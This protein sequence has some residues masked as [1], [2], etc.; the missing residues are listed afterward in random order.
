M[1][2][3]SY[4]RLGLKRKTIIILGLAVV[5]MILFQVIPKQ[6]SQNKREFEDNV[7]RLYVAST[8]VY[9]K[10]NALPLIEEIDELNQARERI[11]TIED[12]IK[13]GNSQYNQSDLLNEIEVLFSS[14]Y[15]ALDICEEELINGVD[16]ERHQDMLN[17]MSENY[18]SYNSITQSIT[19]SGVKI[20]DETWEK[21]SELLKDATN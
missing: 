17:K 7:N 12:E 19:E 14:A 9:I 2:S 10:I 16:L 3:F 21:F 4:R 13:S 20:S 5:V 8:E 18:E 6:T 15:S 1:N 11:L